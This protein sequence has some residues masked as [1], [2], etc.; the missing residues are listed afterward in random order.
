MPKIKNRNRK[1]LDFKIYPWQKSALQEK[2][3][4]ELVISVE[5]IPVESTLVS[6]IVVSA[7]EPSKF[8]PLVGE[9]S[10]QWI[11]NKK[12]QN[13]ELVTGGDT[14]F[15]QKAFEVQ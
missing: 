6:A 1:D 7:C 2:G 15:V 5:Y 10:A 14:R 8:R 4:D 11:C 12:V 13:K 9:A 3:Q